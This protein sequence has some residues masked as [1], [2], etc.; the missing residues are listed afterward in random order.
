M[1]NSIFFVF[2]TKILYFSGIFNKD[3]GWITNLLYPLFPI[4]GPRN[5]TKIEGGTPG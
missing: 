5:P 3:G 2:I 1:I 4:I